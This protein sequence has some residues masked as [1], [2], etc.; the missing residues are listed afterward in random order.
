MY[1]KE[2][3]QKMYPDAVV[4]RDLHN[5]GGAEGGRRPFLLLNHIPPTLL[6]HMKN[7]IIEVDLHEIQNKNELVAIGT[8][9]TSLDEVWESGWITIQKDMQRKL[10][11]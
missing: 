1:S 7:N 4:L 11:K 3:V 10:A 8:W 9:S 6:S 5:Y 2:Q